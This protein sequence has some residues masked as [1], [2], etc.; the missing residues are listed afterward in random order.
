MA[1][2]AS[3][4][5]DLRALHARLKTGRQEYDFMPPVM[6]SH[7]PEYQK[8]KQRLRRYAAQVISARVMLLL[9][10]TRMTTQGLLDSFLVGVDSKSPFSVLLAARAQLELLA[11]VV[12]T[13]RIIQE[14]AGEHEHGFVARVQRVDNALITA[15]YGTRSSFMKQLIPKMKVSRHR[16]PTA[17]DLEVLTSRNVIT[18]LEKLAKSGRY[19]SC[20][21]DYERLCEYVHPNW[22]MNMLYLVPS[23]LDQRLVRLSLTSSDPFERALLVSAQPM[24]RAAAATVSAFDGLEPPFGMGE[25]AFPR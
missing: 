12:D 1:D 4:V 13:I 9:A 18:R 8:D 25:V 15:T 11:V 14:N 3:T 16:D 20:K 7:V 19:P 6:V 21:E 24:E 23:P 5:S 2:Q 22:G 10:S 17:E